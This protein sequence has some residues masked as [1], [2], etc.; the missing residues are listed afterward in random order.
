MEGNASSSSTAQV[1][2]CADP[3]QTREMIV[4]S[5]DKM[6]SSEQ[7]LLISETEKKK[8]V[9]QPL[10]KDD[11]VENTEIVA[12]LTLLKLNNT[13]PT[14]KEL[15]EFLIKNSIQ[16]N[17]ELTLKK[18]E[19][20]ATTVRL[21]FLN[22]DSGMKA[23]AILQSLNTEIN[24]KVR[25]A[26]PSTTNE[27]YY[28]RSLFTTIPDTIS[29]EDFPEIIQ[30]LNADQIV[31]KKETRLQIY[32][33]NED[34]FFH[35]DKALHFIY[36]NEFLWLE[37]VYIKQTKHFKVLV[38]KNCKFVERSRLYKTLKKDL[39]EL[40]YIG[41]MTADTK[42]SRC[43]LAFVFTAVPKEKLPTV[44]LLLQ[45]VGTV[46][47]FKTQKTLKIPVKE[48]GS[49][50]TQ[51]PKQEKTES[52]Q[53]TTKTLQKNTEISLK[54]SPENSSSENQRKSLKK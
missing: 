39:K 48:S 13:Q 5:Q 14:L 42:E 31:K 33:K 46:E 36:K 7:V 1:G 25:V 30:Q 43:T 51:N 16:L 10:I 9:D 53:Q 44:T 32:W 19:K 49:V 17:N 22:T 40:E 50:K 41:L 28:Y 15:F 21:Y 35:Y 20:T 8:E 4:S 27:R 37:P 12:D 47:R 18:N 23:S 6:V 54:R 38:V 26:P 11:F 45:S 52:T 24:Y 34:S 29:D 2:Q 3:K